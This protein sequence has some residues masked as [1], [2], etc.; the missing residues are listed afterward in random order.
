MVQSTHVHT[1]TDVHTHARTH[2]CTHTHMYTHTHTRTHARTQMLAYKHA[3]THTHMHS[4][5]YT[6]HDCYLHQC[7][8]QYRTILKD[9]GSVLQWVKLIFPQTLHT[10]MQHSLVLRVFTC[11]PRTEQLLIASMVSFQCLCRW[12]WNISHHLHDRK[13]RRV[14]T[15]IT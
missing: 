7:T 15:Y 5:M 9:I 3:H 2:A 1:H 6:T 10:H 13:H 11:V 4:H 8:M 14:Y 12:H